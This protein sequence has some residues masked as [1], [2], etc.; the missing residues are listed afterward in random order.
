M[1]E[2]FEYLGKKYTF[3]KE[4]RFQGSFGCTCKDCQDY[5]KELLKDGLVVEA[6]P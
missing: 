3:P 2:V 5:F 1:T 4:S 6:K